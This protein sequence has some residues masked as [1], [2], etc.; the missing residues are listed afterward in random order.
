MAML[1]LSSIDAA[2]STFDELPSDIDEVYSDASTCDELPPTFDADASTTRKFQFSMKSPGMN[3]VMESKFPSQ[4]NR[5]DQ[6]PRVS[7][8][9]AAAADEDEWLQSLSFC[10]PAKKKSTTPAAGPID[11]FSNPCGQVLCLSGCCPDPELFKKSALERD[12]SETE[13]VRK[14]EREAVTC[15]FDTDDTDK[16]FRYFRELQ[17]KKAKGQ[18]RDLSELRDLISPAVYDGACC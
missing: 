9:A 16:Y 1:N 3:E 14:L 10:P 7:D 18:T 11:L 13:K 6:V 8:A 15:S 12:E 5:G 2:P 17:E 4:G